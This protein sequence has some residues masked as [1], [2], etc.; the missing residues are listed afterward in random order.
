MLHAVIMAGGSGTRFWPKSRADMPKQLLRLFGSRSLLQQTADRV[1]GVVPAERT[2]VI[3]NATQAAATRE[4]LPAL[5]AA[6]I[7]VEPC[8]RDTAA[9]IGLTALVL[10]RSDPDGTMFVLPAD[11][12][13]EPA[14]E[15]HRALRAADDLVRHEASALVTIG[16]PPTYA[17]TVYG[18][19]HR[20][21]RMGEPLGIAAYRAAGFRE[22][23]APELADEYLQ[24]GEYYWNAGIF[25]WRPR[26]ILEAIQEFQPRLQ[27][28][29]SR[30]APT[31]GTDQAAAVIADEYPRLDKISIDY[32]VMER[33]RNVQVI[34][35]PF[36]WDDVGSWQAVARV[37]GTDAHGNTVVGSHCG[38]DTKD[39]I[40]VS[41]ADR[42]IA[43]L[44]V[45]DLVIVQAGNATLV[46]RRQAEGA[47]KQ[48][49]D[50][51]RRRGLESY[52]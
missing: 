40:V 32:A 27:A 41:D 4:Q 20:G 48:L 50:E 43:T 9:A 16:V 21:E 11:H 35:A 46:A 7:I 2:L 28:A 39:C 15:F 6:N 30:I 44:D 18:Y 42:L 45:S 29:L 51:L 33:A 8:G 36:R 25:A 5:A 10:A 37:L 13:I 22:K 19:I 26:T 12:L 47:V 49:V 34:E 52:L 17:A 1:A 3:T 23:P 31:L 38:V 14:E 24:S